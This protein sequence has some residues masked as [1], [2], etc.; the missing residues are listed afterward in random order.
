VVSAKTFSLRTQ[1][2]WGNSLFWL[3]AHCLHGLNRY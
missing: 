2:D 1:N 3:M